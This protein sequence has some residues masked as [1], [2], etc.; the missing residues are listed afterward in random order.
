MIG[1]HF[2]GRP[3]SSDAADEHLNA[4]L[5]AW[6]PAECGA[7]AVTDALLGS[8]NPSG[9]LP[10]CVAR[11]AGQIPVYYNHPANCAW[12]QGGSIGFANYVDLPHAPRYFFGYGLSYTSFAYSDLRLSSS[13]VG[14][15]GKVEIRC[16]VKNIGGMTGTEVV[17]LYLHDRYAGMVRPVKELA[18]FCR[19][20]L[21]AGEEKTVCFTVSG[22]QM[23]Y[24]DGG[25]RWRAEKGDIDV[26]IGASSHD[27]RLTGSYTVTGT[28]YYT[29]QGR[30]LW[31]DASIED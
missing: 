25:M 1:V 24:L 15:E 26:E 17:Q 3:I 31:A 4:I 20:T 14:P 5:E 27:I 21:E 8:V 6:N 28:A 13:A 2:D 22:G 23:A 11:N 9:R 18:G 12:D 10:V 16:R 29:S 30:P 7:Q 19:V